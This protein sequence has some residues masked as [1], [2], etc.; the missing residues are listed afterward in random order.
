MEREIPKE[1][2]INGRK[3]VLIGKCNDRLWLYEDAITGVKETFTLYELGLLN[4]SEID[5]I[6]NIKGKHGK[7][8][9][10]TDISSGMK[11]TFSSYGEAG[12]FLEI[13]ITT[14]YQAVITKRIVENTKRKIYVKYYN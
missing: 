4:N 12:A 10:I 9:V 7:Q 2:E 14:V 8:I 5:A 11:R 1:K 6:L 3:Y 13:S